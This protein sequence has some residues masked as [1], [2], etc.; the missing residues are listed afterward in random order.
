MKKFIKYIAF[1]LVTLIALSPFVLH[2]AAETASFSLSA[3]AVCLVDAESGRVLYGKNENVK[4]PMASTTKIMT[5]ILALE[6][7]IPLKTVITVPREAVGIEGSSLYLAEGEKITLEALIYGLLL[8]SANDASIAIAIAVSG[9]VDEF[10]GLMNH[11]ALSLGLASTSFKNPHGLY[12]DGH[13]TTAYELSL[14]MAYCAQNETFLE[15]S[16]SQR[17]VFPRGDE[18]SRVMINHNRLLREDVGVIAGKTGFTK[19]SGRTLVTLAERDGLRLIC[20]TLNAPD[21]WNDHKKLYEFGFQSY[22][23]TNFESISFRIPIISGKQSHITLKSDAISLFTA[24]NQGE[25]VYRVTAPRF[26]FAPVKKGDTV[27][28]VIFMQNG[29]RIASLPLVASED[30]NRISYSFDIIEWLKEIFSKLRM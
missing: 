14:L 25:V 27:G 4:L 26:V 19:R 20:C 18:L 17:C 5:A 1:M 8:C 2:S 15:I 22:Q 28:Q 16:S 3:Q 30:C 6:S 9:S 24:K 11:K 23:R 12:E 21:D 7:G 10:V 29:K 13:Y